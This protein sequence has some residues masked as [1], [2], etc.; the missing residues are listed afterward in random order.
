MNYINKLLFFCKN[1]M[2]TLVLTLV[3]SSQN[4]GQISLNVGAETGTVDS[5]LPI[6]LVESYSKNGNS[7][8]ESG[9]VLYTANALHY[10]EAESAASW[11][12]EGDYV[13][14]FYGDGRNYPNPEY[15]H[16]AELANSDPDIVFHP[17]EQWYYSLSFLPPSEVWD[18]DTDEHSNV[19]VQW[20]QYGGGAPNGAIRLSNEGD[21]TIYARSE[22]H[23]WEGPGGTNSDSYIPIATAVPDTWNDLKIHVNHTSGSDGFIKIWLNGELIFENEGPTLY[24]STTRGYMKFGV[25][26][27]IRDERIF[28]YDAVRMSNFIDVPYEEWV[29]DQ[30]NVPSITLTSPSSGANTASGEN[31]IL[32]A[33]AHDPAG[34]KM[35][36]PGSITQVEF[37]EGENSIGVVTTAPYNLTWVSP[38]DGNYDIIAVVTDADGNQDTSEIASVRVGFST[39]EISITN[40][41][42]LDN[43]TSGTNTTITVNTSDTDGSITQ[44]EFFLN[45]QSLGIDTTSP[46]SFD[47]TPITKDAYLIKA[48]ATNSNGKTSFDEIS[49]T[50]DAII[51]T[52]SVSSIHDATIREGNPT[53]PGNWSRVDIYGRPPGDDLTVGIFKFD[54]SSYTSATEIRDVKLKLY[55]YEVNDEGANLTVFSAS[56]DDWNESTVTWDHSDRP[57]RM[58]SLNTMNVTTEGI[59]YEFDVTS[60]IVEKHA[61]GD[62]FVTFWVQDVEGVRN[63]IEVDSH[64]RDN[65]PLLEIT[66][67]DVENLP[68]DE[69]N[70][71]VAEDISEATNEDTAIDVTLNASD[72]DNDNL[73]YSIVTQSTNGSVSLGGTKV[74]YTPNTN[75]NGSDSFTYKVNDG[76]VDSNT[77]TVTITV[78][79]TLGIEEQAVTKFELYPNPAHDILNIGIE[80]VIKEVQIYTLNGKLVRKVFNLNHNS[81]QVQELQTG[82][83]ILRI[84]EEDKRVSIFKLIKK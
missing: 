44:V 3:F 56:G 72:V 24:S 41:Q 26:T 46:Y 78:D 28:Y 81:L 13:L 40:P 15:A 50:V 51:E 33:D 80:G 74:T 67:G 6:P 75:F 65:P 32:T 4:Y 27:Q 79:K 5:G 60:F 38:P 10:I 52:S 18:A 82:I 62:S 71:P 19:I 68:I 70:A 17:G 2:F 20:K 76:T 39:P 36:T 69:N 77:A 35:G 73:I 61:A 21:Y 14:K 31:V 23:E 53:T 30:V 45:G 63:Q 9:G 7:T 1:Q 42:H 66:I 83:Y 49:V 55:A 29:L 34:K 57:Q 12:R 22:R 64:T 25:Y 8:V 54:I 58:D 59:Y 48:V 47:W 84:I 16:R 11:A 37:F 43:L